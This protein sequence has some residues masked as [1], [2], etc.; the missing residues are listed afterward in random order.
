MFCTYSDII[1]DPVYTLQLRSDISAAIPVSTP[2]IYEVRSSARP[3]RTYI[4]LP[5]TP[6][7]ATVTK[8]LRQLIRIVTDPKYPLYK[9]V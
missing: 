1:V 4:L 5:L 2:I 7:L 6:W 3:S 8:L 9:A